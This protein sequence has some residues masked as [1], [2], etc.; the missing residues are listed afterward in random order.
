MP[1]M[2]ARCRLAGKRVR[3][4]SWAGNRSSRCESIAH[5]RGIAMNFDYSP[6][7]KELESRLRAFMDAN[8]YPNEERFHA[9][10]ASGDRWQPLTLIEELKAKAKSAGLWN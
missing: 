6:K 4:R 1:R 3:S 10:V 5:R 7:V 2:S 9:E 8:V